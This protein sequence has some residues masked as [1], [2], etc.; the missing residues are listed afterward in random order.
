[1]VR[2]LPV[3]IL[4]F[5]VGWSI[6]QLTGLSYDRAPGHRAAAQTV[7]VAPDVQ[8]FAAALRSLSA[9]KGGGAHDAKLDL[10][11]PERPGDPLLAAVRWQLR[12]F[13]G[14]RVVGSLPADV[15]PIVITAAEDQP[16]LKARY[17][18]A[19]FPILETW[20]PSNLGSFNAVL[21]WLLYREAKTE[22]ETQK[23]ILWVDR[24]QR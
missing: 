13:S 9:L 5:G 7:T 24:T 23:V 18:G 1:M 3:V 22:P 10:V 16:Q 6:S 12:D 2:V 20:R 17:S 21:R 8:N 11:W 19:E 4:L 14:L 15:A